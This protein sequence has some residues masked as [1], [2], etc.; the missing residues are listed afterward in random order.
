MKRS[1]EEHRYRLQADSVEGA[2]GDPEALVAWLQTAMREHGLVWMLAHADDGVIWGR[3]ADGRLTT[4]HDAFPTVSPAPDPRT[5][6]QVRLFSDDKEV[7]LWR[8]DEGEWRSRLLDDTGTGRAGWRL[9]EEHLQWGDHLQKA[10]DE[11][12]FTLVAEGAQGFR[13]A[14][15]IPSEETGLSQVGLAAAAHQHP[16][17][18]L[19]RHYLQAE[20]DGV[21]RIVRSRLRG[22]RAHDAEGTP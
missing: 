3:F 18:L 16:V 10:S 17:R 14:V 8:S 13:H 12:G 4:S 22:L 2:F 19:V 5:L 9:D 20:N 6:R 1:V 15:P 21:L 7:F 11:H